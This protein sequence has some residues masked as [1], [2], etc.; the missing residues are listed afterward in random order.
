MTLAINPNLLFWIFS[1]LFLVVALAFILPPLLRKPTE[2]VDDR[3]D[4]NI[5]ITKS[6]LAELEAEFKGGGLDKETY[7]QAKDE[8]EDGLYSDLDKAEDTSSLASTQRHSKLSIL[9]V[10]LFVPILAVGLYLK[11]GKIDAIAESSVVRGG[12]SSNHNNQNASG[13]PQMSM[14]EIVVKL[15]TKL[16]SEPDN[17][18]GWSML[19]RTYMVINRPADAVTAYTKALSLNPGD[20]TLLL[21]LA[22]ALATSKEGNLLGKPEEYIQQALQK[23]P[24]NLMGLWLAGMSAK[25]RGAKEEAIGYWNKVLPKLTAGSSEI[26]EVQGLILEAGGKI[27]AGAGSAV[28]SNKP[29]SVASAPADASS[30]GDAST[31]T[32]ITVKIDLADELKSKANPDHTVFIYAKAVTGPPMP[33]AAVRKQ[34]KDLPI[35]VVLDDSMAMMPQLKISGFK[36]VTVGARVSVGGTPTKNSGDLFTE[37]SP[38]ALGESLMLTIDTVAE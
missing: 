28:A 14:E 6:Q 33:L 4:Q 7:L 35:E 26:K 27:D 1:I 37:Q 30:M 19:G 36:Q 2:I 8:L 34:V 11:Y 3:R 15:E 24:E 17:L 25:Q 22:D 16:K 10:A 12:A 20:P 23:E 9:F 13:K 29:A 18:K 38:V 31:K 32:S 21:Q 5:S